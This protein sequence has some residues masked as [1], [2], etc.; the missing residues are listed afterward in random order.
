MNGVAGF[1][2]SDNELAE[3]VHLTDDDTTQ[4]HQA[5]VIYLNL[6]I[7]SKSSDSSAS[8]ISTQLALMN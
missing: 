4:I 5:K 7:A 3:E 1:S 8:T 6:S 2:L